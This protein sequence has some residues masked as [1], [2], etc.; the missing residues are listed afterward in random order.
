M[1]FRRLQAHSTPVQASRPEPLW[2]SSTPP[3]LRR[4]IQRFSDKTGP[5]D[6]VSLS[7]PAEAHMSRERQVRRASQPHLK[8]SN[9]PDPPFEVAMRLTQ[10]SAPPAVPW[11]SPVSTAEGLQ[12]RR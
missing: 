2:P 3:G 7:V 9:L 11:N 10:G 5:R 4:F 12:A 6:T 1:I 8:S